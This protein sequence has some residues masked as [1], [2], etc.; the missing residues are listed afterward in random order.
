MGSDGT[1]GQRAIKEHAG[2]A[3]VQNPDSTKFNGMPRSTIAAGLADIV[4]TPETLVEKNQVLS[5]IPPC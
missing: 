3:F 1:L 5:A 4:A 2:A